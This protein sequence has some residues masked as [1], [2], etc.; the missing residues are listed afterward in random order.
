[1][2]DKEKKEKIDPSSGLG[3][4][5]SLAG[6]GLGETERLR[7]IRANPDLSLG[8][9]KVKYRKTLSA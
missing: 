1:M 4:W 7:S 5:G 6:L 2:D 3:R 8:A 9:K